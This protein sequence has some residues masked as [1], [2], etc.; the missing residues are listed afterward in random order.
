MF[1]PDIIKTYKDL[2]YNELVGG[3]KQFEQKSQIVSNDH[4]KKMDNH[5]KV[6]RLGLEVAKRSKKCSYLTKMEHLNV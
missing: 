2:Q 6:K 4:Q 1:R 5:H 3:L